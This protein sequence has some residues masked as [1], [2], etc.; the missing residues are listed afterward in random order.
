MSRR[1]EVKTANNIVRY[2]TFIQYAVISKKS[3]R[4]QFTFASFVLVIDPPHT[5]AT[6]GRRLHTITRT[7]ATPIQDS[8]WRG[9]PIADIAP[10]PTWR[11]PRTRIASSDDW[12]WAHITTTSTR[13]R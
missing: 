10:S 12:A 1:Y 5:R 9:T 2:T 6:T 7:R 11:R 4:F 8:S 3:L 13:A